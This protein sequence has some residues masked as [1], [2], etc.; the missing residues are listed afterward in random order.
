MKPLKSSD[1][2]VFDS[3][4]ETA[5]NQVDPE[6]PVLNSA[7]EVEN[8]EVDN[9]EE[10]SLELVLDDADESGGVEEPIS[11]TEPNNEIM[12]KMADAL[13][14]LAELQKPPEQKVTK[15]ERAKLQQV[16][17][18][19]FKQ[20]FNK[21][22][23]DSDDQ[24]SVML[25]FANKMVAPQLTQQNLKLQELQKNL[26][27]NQDEK[28]SYIFDNYEVEVENIIS[29]FDPAM[30]NHPDAYKYA[31]DQI[32]VK[33]FNKI[34]AGLNKAGVVTESEE[35]IAKRPV[36]TVM[37]GSSS[38]QSSSGSAKRV[39]KYTQRDVLGAKKMGMELKTYL[40]WKKRKGIK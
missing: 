24:F 15:K 3:T 37:A 33:N 26:L 29:S 9:V 17:M 36:K 8:V 27:I 18:N 22:L 25:D 35:P 12:S 30:Q 38:A 21:K 23:L 31:A 19:Q 6:N 10:D 14:S 7:V 13:T 16:D 40:S 11:R 39:Q 28:Y 2:S 20:E 32:L 5:A 34:A 1:A 4:L